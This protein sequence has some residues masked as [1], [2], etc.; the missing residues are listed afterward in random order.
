M[1]VVAGMSTQENPSRSVKIVPGLAGFG[2]I[3]YKS[4]CVISVLGPP[5]DKDLDEEDEEDLEES[6]SEDEEE[7]SSV[8]QISS[9]QNIFNML[10]VDE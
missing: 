1:K 3:R 4:A 10:S 5:E 6:E 7:G 2:W 9:K 8:Q